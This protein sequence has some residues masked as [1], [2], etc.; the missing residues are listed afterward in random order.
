MSWSGPPGAGGGSRVKGHLL[1]SA[2]CPLDS[3]SLTAVSGWR[4]LDLFSGE[5]PFV[6]L[7]A[8]QCI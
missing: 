1:G 2:A 8:L 5:V 4:K 7:S 6:A 3:M